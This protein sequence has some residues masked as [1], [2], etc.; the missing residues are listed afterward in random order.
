MKIDQ[1][2][3]L[4]VTQLLKSFSIEKAQNYDVWI[5]DYSPDQRILDLLN[6][7]AKSLKFPWTSIKNKRKTK[8]K[9]IEINRPGIFLF[10]SLQHY[11]TFSTSASLCKNCSVN[12]NI[13]VYIDGFLT[14]FNCKV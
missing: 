8:S 1:S 10:S 9:E 3:V 2:T 14:T 13:F 7:I 6:E 4:G 11:E 12:F 5:F